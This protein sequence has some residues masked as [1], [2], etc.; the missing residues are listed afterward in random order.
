MCKS[1]TFQKYHSTFLF[2]IKQILGGHGVQGQGKEQQLIRIKA[3]NDYIGM[4]SCQS[5]S[6]ESLWG[7][8]PTAL[9]TPHRPMSQISWGGVIKV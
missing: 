7:K 6:Y 8:K 1:G 2:K 3:I 4:A 5:K 9:L